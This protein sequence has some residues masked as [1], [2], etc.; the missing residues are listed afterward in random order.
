[1]FSIP[2]TRGTRVTSNTKR[3][4]SFYVATIIITQVSQMASLC[5]WQGDESEERRVGHVSRVTCHCITR[6]VGA[7][8]CPSS[9]PAAAAAA[10][11]GGRG[12]GRGRGRRWPACCWRGPRSRCWAGAGRPAGAWTAGTGPPALWRGTPCLGTPWN[13][14]L[15]NH[16]KRRIF[17]WIKPISS[18]KLL[19]FPQILL[20][21]RWSP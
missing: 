19:Y 21:R 20:L 5:F 9:G 4:H 6:R 3:S 15:G 13:L 8:A 10:G 1:M 17:L 18:W 14:K 7:W 2:L 12:G 11:G 16:E